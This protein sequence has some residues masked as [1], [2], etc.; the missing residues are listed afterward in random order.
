MSGPIRA[1]ECPHCGSMDV[2]YEA[3]MITGQKYRC[4]RCGYLGAFIIERDIEMP[5][6]T[7]GV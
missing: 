3:G 2:F 6:D 1:L 4:H 5:P 7:P